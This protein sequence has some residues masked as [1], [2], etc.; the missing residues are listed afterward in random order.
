MAF[1]VGIRA[2]YVA[3]LA[4]LA[5]AALSGGAIAGERP[6][7]PDLDVPYVPTPMPAVEMMLDMGQV[8]AGD[9]VIDLGSGDGRIAIAAAERGAEVL[10]VDLDPDRV[11]EAQENAEQAGVTDRVE[12]REEDLFDTPIADADVLTLY[13]LPSVN[14]DLRPKILADMRPGA[15]VVS[16]AFDMRNW[17]A[18]STRT[19]EGR[20]LYLWIVP[21]DVEGRWTLSREGQAPVQ[22]ALSQRFQKIRG[23][24]EQSG[25]ALEI[26]SLL[27][28]GEHIAFTLGEGEN[29]QRY[30][31]RVSGDRIES[32]APVE[33]LKR[34]GESVT[35]AWQAERES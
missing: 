17:H 18:D 14:I 27:L 31:G 26:G 28:R 34:A 35:E 19:V 4:A 24:A 3:A 21:A 20:M 6:N 9:R 29:R 10:G 7:A 30:Y 12:F 8:E 13:L 1:S 15:R 5:G 23:S 25:Q 33:A 16:H 32:V 2:G 22:I 11:S